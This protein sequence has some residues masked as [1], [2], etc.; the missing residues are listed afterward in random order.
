MKP[1]VALA[2]AG[3]ACGCAPV[4][5]ELQSAKLVGKGRVEVTPGFSSVLLAGDGDSEHLLDHAGVQLAAGVH[6]RVDL[7]VRYERV[8]VEDGAG[9]NVLGFGPK[10]RLF[11]GWAAA[12]VPVGFAFGG[13]VDS[14][15]TWQVHPTLL[16]TGQLHPSVELNW[17]AKYLVTL[18][19]EAGDDLLAF[20]V[21]FGLG[22]ADGR[23]TIRPE[24]GLAFDPGEDGHFDQFSIG[25]SVR[26]R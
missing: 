7:R 13:D 6:D 26:I 1:S 18:H 10:I 19:E 4:F 15:K 23:W 24:Y 25:V 21:G 16:L 8:W 14:G 2:L 3:M 11:E 12:Y 9:I 22:P 5:S 20:N 17:S